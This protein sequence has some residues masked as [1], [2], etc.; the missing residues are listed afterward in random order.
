[1]FV[2]RSLALWLDRVP[3]L[4]GIRPPFTDADGIR[5]RL[6]FN[7]ILRAGCKCWGRNCGRAVPK[8]MAVTMTRRRRQDDAED[9]AIR[10]YHR[11]SRGFAMAHTSARGRAGTFNGTKLLGTRCV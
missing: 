10:N 1:M 2:A 5:R 6:G 7:P 11:C 8:Q 4:C 3:S 9:V